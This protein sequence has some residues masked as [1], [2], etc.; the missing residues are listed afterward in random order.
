[1]GARRARQGYGDMDWPGACT[2]LSHLP[3]PM[4]P[5]IYHKTFA[6]QE[7]GISEVQ[8]GNL[9]ENPADL[10]SSLVVTQASLSGN[11]LPGWGLQLDSALEISLAQV[12]HSVIIP[13][14]LASYLMDQHLSVWHRQLS[15]GGEVSQCGHDAAE[16]QRRSR[17]TEH[18]AVDCGHAS[19]ARV[20]PQRIATCVTYQLHAHPCSLINCLEPSSQGLYEDLENLKSYSGDRSKSP[21][22]VNKAMNPV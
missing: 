15:T 17:A 20:P 14:T 7:I 8:N 18:E 11:H 9:K 10:G 4:W 22:K 12:P 1:M 19:Q 3:L 21:S 2:L 6:F 16:R 13:S 5:L